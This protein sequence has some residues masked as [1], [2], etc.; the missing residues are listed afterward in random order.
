MG[1]AAAMPRPE[2]APLTASI[3]TEGAALPCLCSR[4]PAGNE[5]E[6]E[7]STS[8]Q[9]RVALDGAAADPLSNRAVSVPSPDRSARLQIAD[10]SARRALSSMAWVL[11]MPLATIRRRL[12]G[13]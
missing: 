12:Q 5:I 13:P 1:G 10:R 9:H 7:L 3:G 11:G 4:A 8:A 2:T 6:A